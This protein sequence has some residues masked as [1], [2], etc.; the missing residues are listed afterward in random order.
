[1]SRIGHNLPLWEWCL[2]NRGTLGHRGGSP[3]H[4]F[5]R[6]H[7]FAHTQ[8]LHFMQVLSTLARISILTCNLTSGQRYTPF[9][10]VILLRQCIFP[11]FSFVH[12][13]SHLFV[14]FYV[15]DTFLSVFNSLPYSQA[16]GLYP[17]IYFVH[18]TPSQRVVGEELLPFVSLP[19]SVLNVEPA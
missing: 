18:G 1:M 9:F 14:F 6:M 16:V 5:L 12:N 19:M 4:S 11:R 2:W 3:A 17:T 8:S 13:F 7:R 15:R 10:G